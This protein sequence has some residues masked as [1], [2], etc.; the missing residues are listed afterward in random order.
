MQSRCGFAVW[1]VTSFPIALLNI[2][3]G[4]GREGGGRGGAESVEVVG[5]DLRVVGGG[6][7]GGKG[8]DGRG[9]WVVRRG[10]ATHTCC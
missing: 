8:I 5:G 3:G 2:G 6:R 10:S 7:G 9:K 4:G 1:L